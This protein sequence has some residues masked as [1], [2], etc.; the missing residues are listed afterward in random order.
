[1]NLRPL[2]VNHYQI[3]NESSLTLSSQNHEFKHVTNGIKIK[4]YTLL[5]NDGVYITLLQNSIYHRFQK[6]NRYNRVI[7][8]IDN[9][10]DFILLELN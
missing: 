10:V 6:I 7:S 5:S 8:K 1:M 3:D 4:D 9:L 2:V